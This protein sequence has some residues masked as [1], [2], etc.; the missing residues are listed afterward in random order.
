[1]ISLVLDVTIMVLLAVTIGYAIRLNGKLNIIKNQKQ[2]FA[3]NIKAFHDA[4][5]K[6]I[7][8]VEELHVRGEDICKLI[9][10]KIRNGQLMGDE[11]EFIVNRAKKLE[12][13]R[14]V[15]TRQQPQVQFQQPVLEVRQPHVNSIA[16]AQLLKAMRDR[17]YKEAL[18]G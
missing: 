13:M 6:A 1:M 14:N 4:T 10:E 15:A 9:D 11:I 12:I 7:V 2:D 16:E 5:E 17:E 3:N 18:N 8:A